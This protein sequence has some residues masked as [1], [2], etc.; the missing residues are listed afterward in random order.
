MQV[1]QRTVLLLA[2]SMSV[3]FVTLLHP[4]AAQAQDVI[5]SQIDGEFEGWEGET[6]IKLQ[7][8]QIW[9]QTEYH[10]HYHYAYSPDVI[11]FQTSGGWK[12]KVEGTDKAVGVRQLR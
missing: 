11:I 10:Y 12:M 8:G 4:T 1:I 6:V 2:L 7:N 9:L 3:G 5:E